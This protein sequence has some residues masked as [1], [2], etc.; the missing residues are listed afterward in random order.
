MNDIQQELLALADNVYCTPTIETQLRAI[1]ARYAMPVDVAS[2]EGRFIDVVS[3]ALRKAVAD[4]REACAKAC[5]VEE[6]IYLSP[7]YATGQPLSSVGERG[8]CRSCARA[9]RARTQEKK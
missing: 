6:Q 7:E 8:A 5:E 1:A 9:I 3:A 4:E 2:G